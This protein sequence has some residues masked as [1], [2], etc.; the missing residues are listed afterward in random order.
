MMDSQQDLINQYDQLFT[1]P[2]RQRV[3][4]RIP[5]T[6]PKPKRQRRSKEELEIRKMTTDEK[7]KE[8]LCLRQKMKDLQEEVEAVSGDPQKA[9]VN[10]IQDNRLLKVLFC[11]F[12]GSKQH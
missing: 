4:P 5:E 9:V 11:F 6:A 7:E 1:T 2:T 8:I 12:L 10:L 3:P